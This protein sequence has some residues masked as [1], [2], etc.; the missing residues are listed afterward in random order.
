MV[1]TTWGSGLCVFILIISQ[2]SL[3]QDMKGFFNMK[4]CG[5]F[6]GHIIG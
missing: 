3:F 1:E 5:D 4:S 6:C 2:V